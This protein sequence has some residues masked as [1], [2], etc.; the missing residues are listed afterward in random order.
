MFPFVQ[1]R[2]LAVVLAA[3]LIAGA[4]G[5]GAL[6]LTS[7]AERPQV[8]V[9]LEVE[10]KLV[11]ILGKDAFLA[12]TFNGTVPGPIIRIPL[13]TELTIVLVNGATMT[14]S[15]HTHF[16][17]YDIASDGTSHTLPIGMAPHQADDPLGA[18]GPTAFVEGAIGTEV[19]TGVNPFGEFAPRLDHDVAAPGETRAYHFLA[20]EVGA[21]VYHCHVFPVAEH[22]SRGLF[23]LIEVYPP[24]WTWE[25][26]EHRNPDTGNTDA[27]VTAPDGTRYYEDVVVLTELDP[28]E[29]S[30]DAGVPT[31]GPVGKLHLL[32]FHAWNDPYYLGPVLDGT[33]MRVVVANMGEEVHSWHVHGHNFDVLDKFDPQKRVVFR[34]DALLVAPGQSFETTLVA[35]NPGFWFVHDHMNQNSIAGMIGWLQV[36]AE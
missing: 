8:T 36:N 18:F 9:T 11:R 12:W 23:G 20:D 31:T 15:F 1:R 21:F 13:G 35:R 24:G 10:E 14:H 33:P 5:A 27:W 7:S 32:N 4:L 6:S 30:E 22:I 34:S 3:V 29:L 17:H 19:N 28:T 25:N 16:Q 26:V 2:G